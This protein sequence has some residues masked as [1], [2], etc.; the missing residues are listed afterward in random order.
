[1]KYIQNHEKTQVVTILHS[2]DELADRDL[3]YT[4]MTEL[5]ANL[6]TKTFCPILICV[7][8]T[9]WLGLPAAALHRRLLRQD[10][11]AT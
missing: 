9:A 2:D 3:D 11:P 1:M 7:A 10:A 4:R 5:G 8:A 6:I